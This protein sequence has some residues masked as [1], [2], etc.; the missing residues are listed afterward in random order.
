MDII[1]TARVPG[2]VPPAAFLPLSRPA[3]AQ[4]VAHSQHWPAQLPSHHHWPSNAS[5]AA[6]P[7]SPANSDARQQVSAETS[8]GRLQA[9]TDAAVLSHHAAAINASLAAAGS[10]LAGASSRAAFSAPAQHQPAGWR[11]LSVGGTSVTESMHSAASGRSDRG[12]DGGPSNF[13]Q[14]AAWREP[15]HLDAKQSAAGSE[16]TDQPLLDAGPVSMTNSVSNGVAKVSH[17]LDSTWHAMNSYAG[18]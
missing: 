11:P 12:G 1:A 8:G 14:Q 4:T 17:M 2:A 15:Q 5:I 16:A 18:R 10:R 7:N 6:L 13:V 9:A 3:P